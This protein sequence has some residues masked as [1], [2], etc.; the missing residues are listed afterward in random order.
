MKTIN[1]L[2][3]VSTLLLLSTLLLVGCA[4]TSKTTT[5]SSSDESA[6]HSSELLHAMQTRVFPASEQDSVAAM[7]SSLENAGYFVNSVSHTLE[8]LAASNATNAVNVGFRAIDDDHTEVRIN[9]IDVSRLVGNQKSSG[10]FNIP[11]I[12]GLFAIMDNMISGKQGGRSKR[13][14]KIVDDPD[15]YSELFSKFEYQLTLQAHTNTL[16]SQVEK[17]LDDPKSELR[18]L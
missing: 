12:G 5:N 3:K 2:T 17:S 1:S 13:D 15:Y 18:D 7:I 4:T 16:R 14:D 9:A 6:E 11:Y 10:F 8:F